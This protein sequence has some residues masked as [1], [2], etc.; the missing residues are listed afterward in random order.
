MTY[1]IREHQRPY[2]TQYRAL[3]RGNVGDWL[4]STQAQR[5]RYNYNDLETPFND[6]ISLGWQQSLFGGIFSLQTVHRR[7]KDQVTRG[8]HRAC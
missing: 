1:L 8:E 7:Q 3:S 4:V 5:F 6:E 2:L